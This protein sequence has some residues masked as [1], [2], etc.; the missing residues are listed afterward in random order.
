[1]A[2]TYQV[3]VTNDAKRDINEILDYLVDQVSYQQAVDAR[4]QIIDCI[5][6]LAEMPEARSPVRE[7]S[8]QGKPIIFRQII[9]K[10]AYR[11]IYRIR[12]IQKNVV[13]IRVI[14]VKRDRGFVKDALT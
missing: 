3:V 13:I 11:I 8:E 9:A 10:E 14:H 7:V 5:H 2:G 12:E 1:M 4:R 6:K